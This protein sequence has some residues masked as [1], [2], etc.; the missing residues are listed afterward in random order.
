MGNAAKY[1][2]L[3]EGTARV[4]VEGSSIISSLGTAAAA[5]DNSALHMLSSIVANN[6]AAA[7]GG[8]LYIST[9]AKGSITNSTVSNNSAVRGTAIFITGGSTVVLTRCL[10]AN[11]SSTYGAAVYVIGTCQLLVAHSIFR[12]NKSPL[13]D[14]GGA[15]VIWG[16]VVVTVSS[17]RFVANS[18]GFGPAMFMQGTSLTVS[19]SDFRDNEGYEGGVAHVK[20][21][22]QVRSGSASSCCAVDM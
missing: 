10:V 7:R 18:A 15:I 1:V 14:N 2:L 12:G 13:N 16:S 22:S 8:G 4:S 5:V 9:S 19:D 17:S 21:Q 11:H 3:V 6:V 20:L